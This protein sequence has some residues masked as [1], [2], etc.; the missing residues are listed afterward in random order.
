M[1][2]IL[3]GVRLGVYPTGPISRR[4][5]EWA[6]WCYGITTIPCRQQGDSEAVRSHTT[7]GAGQ[8]EAPRRPQAEPRRRLRPG[9][10][11]YQDWW[12]TRTRPQSGRSWL[13]RT[14]TTECEGTNVE[15]WPSDRS[16]LRYAFYV[17]PCVAMARAQVDLHHV[18]RYQYGL[19]A[20]GRF[21]PHVTL[22]GFFRSTVPVET[23]TAR[24]D[25][26]LAGR[27]AFPV[28]NH[29]VRPFGREA[30][31]LD[32]H[33][34]PGGEP[35]LPLQQLHHAALDALLPLVDPACEFTG[36]RVAGRALPCPPHAGDGR[37]AELAV[38]GGTGLRARG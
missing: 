13:A 36:G 31:V 22:K 3:A 10:H 26:M 17:R 20:A 7:G 12:E 14:S 16:L 8:G 4:R 25:G 24:L 1:D 18:L 21:M 28:F 9:S 27:H 30:V 6:N 19:R 37:R 15:T 2:T 33:D 34:L 23:L 11:L 38:R 35:N 29:G 32:V 5:E